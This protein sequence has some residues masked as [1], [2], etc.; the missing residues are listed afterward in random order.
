MKAMTTGRRSTLE[1]LT[2]R[3]DGRTTG[4]SDLGQTAIVPVLAITLVIGII[5]GLLV[6]N[7]VQSAPLQQQ[8][9]VAVLAHRALQ[10]GENA[11]VTAINANPSLAQCNTNTN[12]NGTCSGIDYGQWNKITGSDT[13]NGDAEY[14]AFGNPQPTFDPNTNTLTNLTVQVVGAANDATAPNKYMFDTENINLSSKNG[15]LT[16]V[17]WSNFESYN[18][19]GVY[20]SCNYNWETTPTAYDIDNE[21]SGCP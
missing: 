1:R 15:F 3:S 17:W 2:T 20:T 14:Y 4:L 18:P 19:S 9:S 8:T 11:Y 6:A 12:G 5:G 16:N 13:D 10:A 21:H 7:V